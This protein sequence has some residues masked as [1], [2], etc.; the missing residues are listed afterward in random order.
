MTQHHPPPLSTFTFIANSGQPYLRHDETG[1]FVVADGGGTKGLTGLHRGGFLRGLHC[2]GIKVPQ[3]C[4]DNTKVGLVA[5]IDEAVPDVAVKN[6]GSLSLITSENFPVLRQVGLG[7]SLAKLEAN[8][9]LAPMYTADSSVQMVYVSRGSG[10]V[11][12]VGF[13]GQNV[14]DTKVQAGK[15]F[16]VPKFFTVSVIAEGE[17]MECFSILTSSKPLFGQLAGKTSVLKAL[18]PSVLQAS[19]NVTPQF[20][21]LFKSKKEV[22][23]VIQFSFRLSIWASSRHPMQPEY[24]PRWATLFWNWA[25]LKVLARRL[26]QA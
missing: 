7:A 20:E 24:G 9:M 12:M 4:S 13:N 11:Q 10:R 14:L 18:S 16:V 3:P 26:A 17:G 1:V 19:L 25:R 23:D 8:A 21:E 5:N 2:G 15:L 22:L 6:G